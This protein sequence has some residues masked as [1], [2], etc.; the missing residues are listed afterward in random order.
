LLELET[1]SVVLDNLSI[2]YSNDYPGVEKQIIE[3]L[4]REHHYTLNKPFDEKSAGLTVLE[5]R[6]RVGVHN[7]LTYVEEPL[8]LYLQRSEE[9]PAGGRLQPAEHR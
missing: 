2:S 9:A 1:H 7:T 6:L 8:C 4:N 5:R 3:L